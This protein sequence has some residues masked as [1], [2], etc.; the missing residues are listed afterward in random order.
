[1]TLSEIAGKRDYYKGLYNQANSS[2]ATYERKRNGHKGNIETFKWMRENA[3]TKKEKYETSKS[4]IESNTDLDSILHNTTTVEDLI[5]G[6]A[7]NGQGTTQYLKK[8]EAVETMV[9]GK[10]NLLQNNILPAINKEITELSTKID[11][12]TTKINQET[13]DMNECARSRDYYYGQANGYYKSYIKYR[14][15]YWQKL[16]DPGDGMFM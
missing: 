14:D 11:E 13:R 9:T 7:Y 6:G 8:L 2:A 15:L 16:N 3:E 5:K 1:M 4:I 12:Y 10:K